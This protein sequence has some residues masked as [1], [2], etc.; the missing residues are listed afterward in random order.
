HL[1]TARDVALLGFIVEFGF[2]F[3]AAFGAA[4][5]ARPAAS[6]GGVLADLTFALLGF[7]FLKFRR[8]FSGLS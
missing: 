1:G 2:A 7:R 5:C 4:L 8:F 3:H 6:L